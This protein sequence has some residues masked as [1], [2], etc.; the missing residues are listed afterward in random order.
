MEITKTSVYTFTLTADERDTIM[1]AMYHFRHA[2]VE[3]SE[4]DIAANSKLL[5]EIEDEQ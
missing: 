4:E 1:R 2:H 3:K 5:C